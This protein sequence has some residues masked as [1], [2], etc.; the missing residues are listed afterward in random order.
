MAFSDKGLEEK[1]AGI[2]IALR[3]LGNTLECDVNSDFKPPMPTL[4][5]EP[6]PQFR[7]IRTPEKSDLKL[8]LEYEKERNITLESRIAHKDALITEMTALQN[9]LYINIEE[10][11]SKISSLKSDLEYSQGKNQELHKE[12]ENFTMVLREKDNEIQEIIQ[13]K[14]QFLNFYIEKNEESKILTKELSQ[15]EPKVSFMNALVRFK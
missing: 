14:D 7:Q 3:E 5:T 6:A 8:L 15:K 10:L 11:Q 9:E 1:I 2:K 4:I 12:I 13:E